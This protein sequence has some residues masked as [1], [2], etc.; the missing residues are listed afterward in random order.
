[1][2]YRCRCCGYRTLEHLAEG[3]YELCPVCY[4]KDDS[5][6]AENENRQG[7]ANVV[8]LKEARENFKKYGAIEERFKENVRP[9]HED[10][11]PIEYHAGIFDKFKRNPNLDGWIE[12]KF[13]EVMWGLGYDMDCHESFNKYADESPLKVNP[14]QSEREKNKHLILPRTCTSG[15]SPARCLAELPCPL[16]SGF[17][18]FSLRRLALVFLPV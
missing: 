14:H 10:E 13:D 6:Q 4:W 17:R 16:R 15:L 18:V 8:S 5:V 9:P 11:K 12:D 3:T 2:K 1:M 7:G